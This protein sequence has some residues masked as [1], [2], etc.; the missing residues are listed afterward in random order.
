M[1]NMVCSSIMNLSVLIVNLSN[2][3]VIRE[4][5]R[6]ALYHGSPNKEVVKLLPVDF[7][8]AGY[9][10]LH[11]LDLAVRKVGEQCEASDRIS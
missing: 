6:I 7:M 5:K 3:R 4:V 8:I 10:G 9:R 11:D 1:R 2:K